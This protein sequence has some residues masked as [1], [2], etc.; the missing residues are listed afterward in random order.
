MPGSAARPR[1][2]GFVRVRAPLHPIFVHFTIALTGTSFLFDALD[3]IIGVESLGIAGWWTLATSIVLSVGTL[4]TGVTSRM[5]LPMQ[6]GA[7]RS[8]LRAHMALGPVFFG[9]L[10][11]VGIW[12]AAL[13]EQG[14]GA[15]A[16]YLAAMAAVTALMTV[17]GYLGGELV[18]RY[19][20]EVEGRYP[21]LP[22]RQR[23]STPPS[24][25]SVS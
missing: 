1:A 13:W 8:C 21:T 18:Y 24:T 3:Y 12:R 5:R 10:L 14:R 11:A 25:G 15:P 19:G 20:A 6:E 17:Q 2:L 7:A 23:S 16:E 22:D 4:V 9:G